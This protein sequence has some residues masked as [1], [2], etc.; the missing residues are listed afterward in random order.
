[1]VS[2][3]EKA[4]CNRDEERSMKG[5]NVLRGH[6]CVSMEA[7]ALRLSDP[8]GVGP[9][10]LHHA[11]SPVRHGLFHGFPRVWRVFVGRGGEARGEG[12]EVSSYAS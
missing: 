3:I 9:R 8:L 12:R 5:M 1:M 6:L 2:V 10:R 4:V 11:R 7:L